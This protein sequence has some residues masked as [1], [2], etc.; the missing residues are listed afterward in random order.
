MG[1]F[2]YILV[3]ICTQEAN[4]FTLTSLAYLVKRRQ[5]KNNL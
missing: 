3:L 4:D 5:Y 1:L 2:L